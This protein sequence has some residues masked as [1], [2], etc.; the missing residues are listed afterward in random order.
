MRGGPL[1]QRELDRT[2]VREARDEI[3]RH[4]P[5]AGAHLHECEH[6]WPVEQLARL[7]HE[8]GY[9]RPEYGADV[10]ARDEVP[11]RANHGARAA[12]PTLEEAA[13]RLIESRFHEVGERD[14]SRV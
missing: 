8:P 10:R 6:G 4:G 13:T 12:P 7:P 2:P 14:R 1:D 11:F 3:G 9:E 5:V